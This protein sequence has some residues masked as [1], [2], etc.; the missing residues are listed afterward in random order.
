[1]WEYAGVACNICTSVLVFVYVG[2]CICNSIAWFDDMCHYPAAP[3]SQS[4]RTCL[5]MCLLFMWDMCHTQ[6]N[7]PHKAAAHARVLVA[8]PPRQETHFHPIKVSVDV[9]LQRFLFFCKLL[10][11]YILKHAQTRTRAHTHMH[12][13]TRTCTRTCTRTLTLTLILLHIKSRK[14]ASTQT[15]TTT[16]EIMAFTLLW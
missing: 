6:L 4:G 8:P 1:M 11:P 3:A 9:F 12:T 2:M 5:S 15:L 7:K 16:L 10:A 13:H 14:H